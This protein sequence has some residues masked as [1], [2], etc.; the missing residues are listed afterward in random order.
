MKSTT[1]YRK[2]TPDDFD[3]ILRLQNKNLLTN[4]N[5]EDLSQGFLTIPISK[6]QLDR[7]SSAHGIFVAIHGTE[8]IGYV[9]AQSLELAV[10]SP[11]IAH[12]I[13]RVKEI[14]FEGFSLSSCKLL[15]YGPVCIEK[16]YRGKGI[17]DR[18]FKL[19]LQTLQ[20]QFDV[21]IGFVSEQNPRSYSAHKNKLGL[22]LIDEFEFNGQKYYTFAFAITEKN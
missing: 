20:G 8:V 3:G 21:G 6:K 22:R 17:L 10:G 7:I 1:Q 14:V 5:D 2:A 4:I 11:L 9:M 18:L 15:N 19:M 13:S 12:M 16:Q